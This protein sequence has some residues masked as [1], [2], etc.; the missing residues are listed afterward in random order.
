M[1]LGKVLAA[2]IQ[3]EL[4][5]GAEVSDKHDASTRSLINYYKQ[6]K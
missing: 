5:D 4:A 6:A 2:G 3:P 1:E